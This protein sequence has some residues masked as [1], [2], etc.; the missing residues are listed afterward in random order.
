[1]DDTTSHGSTSSYI[2]QSPRLPK[3]SA[4]VR[5]PRPAE[6]RGGSFSQRAASLSANRRAP[7]RVLFPC[8]G[9]IG[10]VP[11]G[12]VGIRLPVS[13]RTEAAEV[14]VRK[15]S[16]V[17]RPRVLAMSS[18]CWRKEMQKGSDCDQTKSPGSTDH[19]SSCIILVS[20]SSTAVPVHSEWHFFRGVVPRNLAW[21]PPCRLYRL[22]G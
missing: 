3:A 20:K 7:G 10:P 19:G 13:D 8:C 18:S 1:M 11:D 5:R 4:E 12:W 22:Y 16:P 2:P 21:D 6:A 14:P 9:E 17:G 15:G